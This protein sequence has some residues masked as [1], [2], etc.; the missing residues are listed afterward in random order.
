MYAHNY[1]R[2]YQQQAVRTSSPE[3]LIHKLYDAGA[4]ACVTG[5]R[6]R[7]RKVLVE[8]IKSLDFEAGGE[9]SHQLYGL[10]E[11]CLTEAIDGDLRAIGDVLGG[12]REAWREGVLKRSQ[13]A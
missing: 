8:L 2:Q 6:P 11:F 4:L 13:A 9:L 3:Q 7:L 12:L 1:M 5:D 10:Y